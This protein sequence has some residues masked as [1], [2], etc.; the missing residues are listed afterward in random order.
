MN[1]YGSGCIIVLVIILLG[2]C[3]SIHRTTYEPEDDYDEIP[4]QLSAT[5]SEIDAIGRLFS[6]SDK[7]QRYRA[8]AA[9]PGLPAEA[10]IYLV[11]SSLKHLFSESAKEN[12]FLTLIQN[13]DFTYAAKQ[14]I[15]VRLN[16]LFSENSKNRVLTAIQERESP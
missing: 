14:A 16:H 7:H 12:V 11:K 8:L 10:Q 5:Y 13:P 4:T 9:R 6:E 15:L 2:G 1:R 3:I